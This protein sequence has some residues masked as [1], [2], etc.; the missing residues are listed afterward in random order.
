MTRH[1]MR[2]RRVAGQPDPDARSNLPAAPAA[3]SRALGGVDLAASLEQAIAGL[4]RL[5]DDPAYPADA[6]QA[7]V[8]QA[9]G[10]RRRAAQ[11]DAAQFDAATAGY[12]EA[13]AALGAVNGAL[14]EARGRVDA[15]PE[16]LA[17]VTR[18]A[19]VLD[20]VLGA[21]T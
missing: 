7:F 8:R 19:G 11:L 5:A 20:G 15:L 12:A 21:V 4:D 17:L 13:A 9:V 14:A 1:Q 6:Q 10:L 3:A 18:A 2:A 16:L